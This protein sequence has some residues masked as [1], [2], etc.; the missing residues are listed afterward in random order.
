MI[1]VNL[2]PMVD[3]EEIEIKK[4]IKKVVKTINRV[5]RIGGFHEVSFIIVDEAKIHEINKEYRHIDAPT[6]VISFAEIDGVEGHRLPKELGDIFIC[7]ERTLS[8]AKEYGHS[9][10]RE[11]A[12]LVTH[13]MYHLLGYDHQNESEEKIMF[14]K[15]ENILKIL[16][17][18]R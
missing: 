7:K 3:F 15:Q 16:G 6:D 4:V 12:F 8:Q 13:G 2:V 18:E 11:A 5:E 10:L 17:I 1:K 14:D 9:V